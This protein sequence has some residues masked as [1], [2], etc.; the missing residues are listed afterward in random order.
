VSSDI[1]PRLRAH[2]LQIEVQIRD[3]EIRLLGAITSSRTWTIGI[4]V[5]LLVPLYV[6]N[7]TVLIFLYNAKP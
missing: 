4:V 6:M 3:L 7:V 2:D 5:A 1:E